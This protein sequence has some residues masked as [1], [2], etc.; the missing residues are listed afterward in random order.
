MVSNYGQ[1]IGRPALGLAG[2]FVGFLAVYAGSSLAATKGEITAS[3]VLS[4]LSEAFSF[5][6]T[7]ILPFVASAR[8]VRVDAS[9]A[10]FGL[11]P[12]FWIDLASLTQGGLGFVLL[13][14]IGLGLRNRFRI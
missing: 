8:A 6:L 9:E 3:I 14:L 5:S 11:N 2:V 12:G 13:F 10:L 1:S 4:R 7:N